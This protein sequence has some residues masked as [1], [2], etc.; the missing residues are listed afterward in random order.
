[1]LK[2]DRTNRRFRQI[3][4]IILVI[5]GNACYA[6]SFNTFLIGNNIAPGGFSGIASIL[7]YL[8][9]FSV[10]G[11]V[12]V[13]NVP[14]FIFSY[15][16]LGREFILKSFF[17]VTILSIFLDTLTILPNATTDRLMAS[18]YG[19]AIMGVG[20]GCSYIANAAAGGTELLSRVILRYNKKLTMGKMML[21]A[22]GTVVVLAI[23]VYGNI[24]SGLY[25]A[26]TVF[27]TSKVADGFIGGFDYAN[28]CYIVTDYPDE[29]SEKLMTD[30]RRG[31]TKL[32]GTGMYT[33]KSKPVL[34]MVIRKTEAVKVKETVI[35]VDPN[36]FM[37]VTEALEV[38]GEGFK[39][40]LD[41]KD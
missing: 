40:V 10:G 41:K 29:I 38:L 14:L 39:T 18:I 22:D 32:Q 25:A 1:M 17:S 34:M 8:T 6:F 9:G 15:K 28:I 24:E 35:S 11:L 12:F 23:L 36:A 26:I 16:K 5:I 3:R 4:S 13:M 30:T 27:L 2:I 7:N 31:V 21:F 33:K 37:I 19:G 20:I